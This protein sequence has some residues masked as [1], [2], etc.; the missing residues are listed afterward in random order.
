MA[1]FVLYM[2]F[3]RELDPAKKSLWKEQINPEAR[4]QQTEQVSPGNP[5]L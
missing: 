5:A 2:C 4:E 3:Q 1:A